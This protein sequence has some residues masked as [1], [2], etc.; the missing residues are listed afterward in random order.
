M[1][2][3]PSQST[4]ES[5]EHYTCANVEGWSSA[6]QSKGSVAHHLEY[7]P[8][9]IVEKLIVLR[10]ST[11]CSYVYHHLAYHIRRN[12]EKQPQLPWNCICM[13]HSYKPVLG[14][15]MHIRSRRLCHIGYL[16][17]KKMRWESTK[18]YHCTNQS[19]ASQFPDPWVWRM[20]PRHAIQ[21]LQASATPTAKKKICSRRCS[22]WRI[23]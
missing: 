23:L 22:S 7:G 13:A 14:N 21:E 10:M 12:L 15:K 3:D 16:K 5:P 17:A 20:S 6:H 2:T 19:S 18:Q 1:I 11:G 8:C 4:C 9:Y